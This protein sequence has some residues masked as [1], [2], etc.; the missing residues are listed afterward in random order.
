MQFLRANLDW[1]TNRGKF[2][3]NASQRRKRMRKWRKT[4]IIFGQGRMRKGQLISIEGQVG[5]KSI[6]VLKA[7]THSKIV[8]LPWIIYFDLLAFDFNLISGFFEQ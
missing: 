4:L 8:S 6:S 3:K 2:F 1:L 7:F 5:L